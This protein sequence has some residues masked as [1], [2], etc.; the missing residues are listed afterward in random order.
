MAEHT[1]YMA[2]RINGIGRGISG[3]SRVSLSTMKEK[4]FDSVKKRL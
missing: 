2:D 1:K 3:G 4:A